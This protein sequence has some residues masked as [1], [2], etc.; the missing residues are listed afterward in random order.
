MD[1]FLNNFYNATQTEVSAALIIFN[2]LF[3]FTL[4]AI[5]VWVWRRTHKGLSYSQSFAITIMMISPL[6]TAVMMI[7]QNNLVGAFALLG[8]F[9]LI[10]FRTIMKETRD[11]AFLFF[12]L[13]IG[14]STGTGYYSVALL[15]TLIVSLIVLILYRF[16]FASTSKTGFI[17]TFHTENNFDTKYLT[18]LFSSYIS[19]HELL[20]EKVGSDGNEYAYSLHFKTVGSENAFM[21]KLRSIQGITDGYLIT[22]KDT[23]EY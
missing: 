5:I 9:S 16:N 19:S 20:H 23:I 22:G 7:V 1:N 6:A 13:T 21:N 10:R 3:S 18:D 17:L 8:A 15:T 11:I 14:V 12:A 2:I 4:S